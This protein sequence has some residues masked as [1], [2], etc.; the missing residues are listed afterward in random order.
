[1]DTLQLKN[2]E[3]GV[4][5]DAKKALSKTLQ[6]KPAAYFVIEDPEGGFIPAP[7]ANADKFFDHVG[8]EEGLCNYIDSMWKEFKKRLKAQGHGVLPNLHAVYLVYDQTVTRGKAVKGD[9]GWSVTAQ[10]RSSNC[11]GFL[12]A[13]KDKILFTRHIYQHMAVGGIDFVRVEGPDA[14]KGGLFTKLYP[15]SARWS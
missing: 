7:I 2:F 9:Q 3:T 4:V 6:V 12:Q 11:I 5:A 13:F 10:E 15:D 14:W 8:G 1:M